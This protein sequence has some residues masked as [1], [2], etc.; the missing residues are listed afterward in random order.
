MET[1]SRQNVEAY[2]VRVVAVAER[3]HRIPLTGAGEPGDPD[4]KTGERWDRLNLL[5]HTAEML[6]HW[7]AQVQ[8]GA[9]RIGRGEAERR[10]RRAGIDDAATAGEE[11]LRRRLDEGIEALLA[12]LGGLRDADLVR[13]VDCYGL[14]S[15]DRV[16]TVNQALDELIVGHLE[17][18]VEQLARST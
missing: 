17:E 3:L 4:P 5:G 7:V 16:M 13:V 15:G 8:S 10:R 2:E 12:L 6:P 18:H 1:D 11:E 14:S 9:D